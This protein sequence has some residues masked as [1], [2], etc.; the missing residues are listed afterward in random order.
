MRLSVSDIDLY[1]KY[2]QEDEDITLKELLRQLRREEKRPWYMEAGNA[3]HKVLEH[4]Q[5]GEVAE[6]T[7]NGYRFSFE[8]DHSVVLPEIREIKG[9]IVIPT[10]VGPVTLVGKVDGMNY[11]VHDYKLTGWMQPEKYIDSYQ[12]RCYLQMFRAYRFQYDI[13]T[14][15]QDKDDKKHLI[16]KDYHQLEMFAYPNME[17][18]VVNAVDDFAKFVAEYL[19]EKLT[20]DDWQNDPITSIAKAA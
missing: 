8:L 7:Y 20:A 18:D 13:F 5:T 15:D 12:W 14:Y 19:P 2:L 16:V 9:E 6:A 17:R 11:S 4:A 3:F 10:S 1:R